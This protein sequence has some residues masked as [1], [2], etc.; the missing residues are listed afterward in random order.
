LS[1]KLSAIDGYIGAK[2]NRKQR[3]PVRKDTV[4]DS[5]KDKYTSADEE[6]LALA[7]IYSSVNKFAYGSKLRREAE[8]PGDW[9]RELARSQH[10]LK[11]F[12]PT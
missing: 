9:C 11:G 7:E 3:D 4:K 5:G 6:V 12:R 8:E 2:W 10:G 1:F